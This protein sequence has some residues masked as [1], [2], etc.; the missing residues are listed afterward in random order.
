MDMTANEELRGRV[1]SLEKSL[2]QTRGVLFDLQNVAAMM[3]NE[4]ISLMAEGC[5]R[6]AWAYHKGR[7]EAAGILASMIEDV[8]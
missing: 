2:N 4:S 7:S 8:L 5:S 1:L 6:G 3:Y